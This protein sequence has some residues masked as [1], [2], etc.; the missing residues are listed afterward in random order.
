M[1][2]TRLLSDLFSCNFFD[3]KETNRY[4]HKSVKQQ[5]SLV[6]FGDSFALIHKHTLRL[7]ALRKAIKLADALN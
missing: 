5:T 2:G 7:I 6:P 4:R 3:H 1:S